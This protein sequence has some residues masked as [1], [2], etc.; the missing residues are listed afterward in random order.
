LAEAEIHAG[1]IFQGQV[2]LLEGMR[3]VT[4]EDFLRF[5]ERNDSVFI[6]ER[7]FSLRV[8]KPRKLEPENFE[9]ESATVWSFPER[10][11][12]ATHKHNASYRGNWAPQVARNLLLLYSREGE[13]VLDPFLGSGTT[14]IECALLKR[15]CIGVDINENSVMLAWSRLEPIMDEGKSVKLFRG[16]ARNLD[17]IEDE[18]I[19]F[20]AGHPPY[21]GIIKYSRSRE[22]GGDLSRLNVELYLASMLE[23]AKEM[24][25]VLK[26]KRH[27]AIMIGDSRTR[28]HVVPLGYMVMTQFLRA[29]FTLREHIIKVQHNMVGTIAWRKKKERDFLLLKH[30]HIFVFEKSEEE[31]PYSRELPLSVGSISH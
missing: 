22:I 12:W 27:A 6:G 1:G 21:A 24:Y 31:Y 16:D 8:P 10:G 30:E 13:V 19:D 15:K 9:L 26:K 5:R 2:A 7:E 20:I 18:S 23:V 11:K 29:G 17:R 4:F 25:R 28:K 3:E 14:V